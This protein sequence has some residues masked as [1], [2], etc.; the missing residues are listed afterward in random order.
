M[1]IC[2]IS[3]ASERAK[4]VPAPTIASGLHNT[5]VGSL[6][7]NDLGDGSARC[8]SVEASCRTIAARNTQHLSYRERDVCL[9]PPKA[10]ARTL[11]FFSAKAH[12]WSA[13]LTYSASS[14]IAGV[15]RQ[16][17]PSSTL[18]AMVGLPPPTVT[19]VR[20]PLSSEM[21]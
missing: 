17:S 6:G 12:R 2:G 11:Y 20:P 18:C 15:A 21:K 4:S 14:A 10:I 13:V 8:D 16:R 19:T 9:E 5:A 1:R 3:E 7:W